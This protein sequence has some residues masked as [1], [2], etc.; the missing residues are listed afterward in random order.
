MTQKM[1]IKLNLFIVSFLL[2]QN[3][4]KPLTNLLTTYLKKFH[5]YPNL[6]LDEFK[7]YFEPRDKIIYVYI[8]L[9]DKNEATDF[10]SFYSL[11]STVVN[12]PKHKRIEAA[13]S[14]YNVATSISINQ[15]IKDALI[16]ACNAGFDVFNALDL[17]E[18]KAFLE[19]MKF[20][21]GDGNLQ[22]YLYNWKTPEMK[23]EEVGLVLQ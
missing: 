19:D 3:I 17:M 9:N 6:T 16:L 5:L 18:N 21:I 10:I 12:N 22:Y 13:Y 2:A 8:I 11:P 4:W 1:T 23:P 20:G 15:L 7:H 14:Y